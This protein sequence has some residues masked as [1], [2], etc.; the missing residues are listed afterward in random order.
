[1]AVDDLKWCSLQRRLVR[2]VV[3]EFYPRQPSGPALRAIADQTAQ[4]DHDDLVSN[5][6]LAVS[7]RLE[8]RACPAEVEELPPHRAGEDGIPTTD[9]GCRD[10]M[11]S[12][13]LFEERHRDH[14]CSIWV[15][16]GNEMGIFGQEIDHRQ[17]HRLATHLRKVVDIVHGNALP[18]HIRHVEW[19]EET[20]CV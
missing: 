12:D 7:L 10:A 5:L 15:A 8:R 16:Q 20:R 3:A 11:K 4:V 1:V 13:D 14:P 19:L 2:G 6:R 9:D 18:H 17:D